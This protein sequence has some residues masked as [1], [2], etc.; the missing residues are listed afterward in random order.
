MLY[1]TIVMIQ[2]LCFYICPFHL[3]LRPIGI[4]RQSNWR[5]V[6]ISNSHA[7]FWFGVCNAVAFNFPFGLEFAHVEH[8]TFLLV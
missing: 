4:K 5:N 7:R 2:H 6:L 3:K 8:L 1:H